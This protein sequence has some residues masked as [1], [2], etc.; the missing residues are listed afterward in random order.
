MQTILQDGNLEL[1]NKLAIPVKFPLAKKKNCDV[2]A[3]MFEMTNPV[4]YEIELLKHGMNIDGGEF[5]VLDKQKEN[6][7]VSIFA[8]METYLKS[9]KFELKKIE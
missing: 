5:A 8:E 4:N 2:L 3:G 9:N 1:S 6:Y 7:R